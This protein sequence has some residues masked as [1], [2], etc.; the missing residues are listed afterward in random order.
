MLVE[1]KIVGCCML[2]ECKFFDLFVGLYIL[3]SLFIYFVVGEV[4]VYEEWQGS[5]G[6]LWVLIEQEFLS[7]VVVGKI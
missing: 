4:V 5:V 3:W 7:G 1:I 2:F 6:V